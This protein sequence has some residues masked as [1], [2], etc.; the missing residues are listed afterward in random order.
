VPGG[1]EAFTW[2]PEPA[3]GR[4]QRGG[5]IRALY[6]AD[7]EATAWAEWMR[8]T[9]ELGLPPDRRLPRRTWQ[10]RVRVSDIADLAAPGVLD[11]HGIADLRPT[12]RQWPGTQPVGE[13]Y[14]TAGARGLLAPSA[15]HDGHRVLALFRPMPTVRGVTPVGR[16]TDYDRL[17]YIPTGL[18]T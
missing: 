17:P 3:D 8:H 15:A 12:R 5:V 9:A 4:W 6:L 16:P 11:A 18:R 7:T 13:A 14:W 10:Y 1:G 2:T